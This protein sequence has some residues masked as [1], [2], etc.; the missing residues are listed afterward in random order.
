MLTKFEDDFFEKIA[1]VMASKGR[2]ISTLFF[3]YLKPTN[4]TDEAMMKKYADLLAKAEKDTT[5]DYNFAKLIKDAIAGLE[6][7]KRG[8]EASQAYLNSKK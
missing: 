1:P 6:T 3:Q 8:R 2:W 7:K 4:R 5:E